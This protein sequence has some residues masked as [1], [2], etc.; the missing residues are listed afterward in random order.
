[1]SGRTILVG[2]DRCT[3][4][5]VKAIK[6]ANAFGATLIEPDKNQMHHA[7]SMAQRMRVAVDVR[8]F[9]EFATSSGRGATTNVVIDG[10][11]TILERLLAVNVAAMTVN[12]TTLEGGPDGS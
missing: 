4:K 6:L 2:T 1:M 12:A 7:E 9:D 3:G 10:A 5:T 8:T 11:D